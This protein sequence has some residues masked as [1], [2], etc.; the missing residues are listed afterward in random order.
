MPGP[1]DLT[2]TEQEVADLVEEAARGRWRPRVVPE[3]EHRGG[4]PAPDLSQA[5]GQIANRAVAQALR[6]LTDDPGPRTL[7]YKQGAL[8]GTD[9][10]DCGCPV[11]P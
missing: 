6:A 10:I 4:E 2:P 11:P 1:I 9:S 3:R 8:K 5:R 7:P